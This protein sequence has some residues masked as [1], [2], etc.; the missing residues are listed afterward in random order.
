MDCY[1]HGKDK[2]RFPGYSSRLFS[3]SRY[4]RWRRVLTRSFPS[5]KRLETQR[6]IKTTTL[7]IIDPAIIFDRSAPKFS[8]LTTSHD[9][10]RRGGRAVGALCTTSANLH[11]LEARLARETR[12]DPSCGCFCSKN[13]SISCWTTVHVGTCSA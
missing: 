10:R 4:T 5:W 1:L 9:S 6:A 2:L 7:M 11:C 12:F 13:G 3:R 8:Q